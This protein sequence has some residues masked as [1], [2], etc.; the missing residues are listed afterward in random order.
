ML[1][2]NIETR[3]LRLESQVFPNNLIGDTQ[4]LP[5]E[6]ILPSGLEIS[7]TSGT[8]GNLVVLNWG[9]WTPKVSTYEIWA[10]G[11]DGRQTLQTTSRFSPAFFTISVDAS[12]AWAFTVRPVA[13]DRS[14]ALEFC[15]TIA[16]S[17]SPPSIG[18]GD[19]ASGA[20]QNQHFDRASA[21]KIVIVDADIANATITQAKLGSASVGTAQI[22]DASITSAKILS[23]AASKIS[24][25]TITS[26]NMSSGTYT[27]TSGSNTME[28]NG[29]NGFIQ[30]QTATSEVVKIVNGAIS[31]FYSSTSPAWRNTVV[32]AG[33]ITEWI[34]SGAYS[35]VNIASDTFDLGEAGSGYFDI[36]NST[37]TIKVALGVVSGGA[38]GSIE[39]N[40]SQVVGPRGAAVADAT[41]TGDVVAQLNALL[42][43]LRASTGHGLIA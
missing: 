12:E 20:I 15:P 25:G 34:N 3:L 13:G 38:N 5:D 41:G 14:V 24:A 43:R 22:I 29:T 2:Q 35:V 23:L 30:T 9:N 26:V 6:D 21:N 8:E 33:A 32:T 27:L 16:A 1:D 36:R 17:L 31:M 11:P 10:E 42:A 28:I 40:G 4:S 37:G 39:I 18:S 19:I 7:V